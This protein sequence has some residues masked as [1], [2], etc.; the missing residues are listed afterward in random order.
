MNAQ[1]LVSY[2]VIGRQI[3]ADQFSFQIS[4]RENHPPIFFLFHSHLQKIQ[5]ISC[6]CRLG[7]SERNRC[8]QKISGVLSEMGAVEKA[9]EVAYAILDANG[10]DFAFQKIS[11]DLIQNEMFDMAA[12]IAETL[13]DE[14]KKRLVFQDIF[15]ALI[16][17]ASKE[18]INK[19]IGI[20]SFLKSPSKELA[21]R[22]IAQMLVEIDQLARAIRV[23]KTIENE[24]MQGIAFQD[25]CKILIKTEN[26]GEAIQTAAKMKH[27]MRKDFVLRSVCAALTRSEISGS[28][29]RTDEAI[30]MAKEISDEN[31]Q[32]GALRDIASILN[33]MARQDGVMRVVEAIS[34]SCVKRSILRDFGPPQTRLRLPQ[35]R[36][37]YPPTA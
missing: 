35:P 36:A 23:A 22:A 4:L 25:I 17:T 20:A 8:F 3:G 30:E 1:E 13:L 2:G 19:A 29:E 24:D 27:L 31:T 14:T 11:R 9:I 15:E 34:D 37:L 32:E 10:R 28:F 6:L 7:F 26:I 12:E 5:E 33:G 16:Q 21:L 18:Y